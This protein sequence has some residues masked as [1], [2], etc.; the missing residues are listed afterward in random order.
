VSD[1][2]VSG[3]G[4]DQAYLRFRRVPDEA[5]VVILGIFG[6]GVIRNVNQYR[7]FLGWQQQPI[8]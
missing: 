6:E 1:Y 4:A 3:Y 2:G 7:G 8:R 5:P